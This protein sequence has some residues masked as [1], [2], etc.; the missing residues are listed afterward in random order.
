MKEHQTVKFQI[1]IYLK[2]FLVD[3]YGGEPLWINQKDKL[4]D[5]LQFLLK[6]P[7]TGW[8]P[9]YPEPDPGNDYIT[10]Q[11]PFY[12]NMNPLVYCYLSNPAIHTFIT[13]VKKKFWITY[14]QH[15][16]KAFLHGITVIDAVRLFIDKHDLPDDH[17]VEEMLR[18]QIYRSRNLH[19]KI[20]KRK[21]HIHPKE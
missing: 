12:K 21:Y 6:K 2:A 11:L 20:P 4:H 18:K 14:E 8:V 1:P 19:R 9:R 15:M 16:D 10:I 17:Q 3:Q 5:L 7:P 13:W